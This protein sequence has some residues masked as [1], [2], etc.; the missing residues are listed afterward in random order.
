V[1]WACPSYEDNAVTTAQLKNAKNAIDAAMASQKSG[2]SS[3]G[4]SAN[5]SSM[6]LRRAVIWLLRYAFTS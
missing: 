4:F 1:S 3:K 6:L 2:D 5:L